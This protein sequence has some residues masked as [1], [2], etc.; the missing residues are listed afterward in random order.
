MRTDRS[1]RH[2]ISGKGVGVGVVW[3]WVSGQRQTTPGRSSAGRAP[4]NKKELRKDTPI[5]LQQGAQ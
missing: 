5:S 3:G 4:N 2:L 1:R